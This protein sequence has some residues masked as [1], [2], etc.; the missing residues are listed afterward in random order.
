[1]SPREEKILF[2]YNHVK[3][4]IQKKFIAVSKKHPVDEIEFLYSKGHRDFGENR[5]EELKL[6]SDDL[7]K[8]CP[9]IKWHFIG[10][11]Q[12]KKIS[13]LAKVSNLY[14]IHSIDSIELLYKLVR[15]NFVNQIRCFLQVNT[16]KEVE[17][18]GFRNEKNLLQ[19]AKFMQG[20]K[21]DDFLLQGL[22]TMSKLRTVNF[23][24]D[25]RKCFK[26]LCE[27]R[28]LI[29]NELGLE[30]ELSMGMSSDFA[31]ALEYGTSWP[32]IG[33]KIFGE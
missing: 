31:I 17:K 33:S 7:S 29:N 13:L 3:N 19:A 16:S 18:F 23:E 1:V 15:K 28:D 27:M 32:R 11:L 2:Q 12:S 6:K 21:S 5:V 30:L 8:K 14:A 9:E 22:M 26:K 25:A 4:I 20:L 24:S 10:H